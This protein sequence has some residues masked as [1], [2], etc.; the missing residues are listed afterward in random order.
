M[1]LGFV[2]MLPMFEGRWNDYLERYSR[3]DV[4]ELPAGTIRSKAARHAIEEEIGNL[5]RSGSGSITTGS[6]RPPLS[7]AR[8]TGCSPRP[9]A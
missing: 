1:F 6:R 7:S 4:E 5:E 8:P 2:R 9:T 3:Y